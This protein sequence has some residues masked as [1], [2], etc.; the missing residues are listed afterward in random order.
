MSFSSP[1][2]RGVGLSPPVTGTGTALLVVVAVAL[3]MPA[4]ASAAGTEAHDSFALRAPAGLVLAR[5]HRDA[6]PSPSEAAAPAAAPA[7]PA[8]VGSGASDLGFDLLGPGSPAEQPPAVDEEKVKLRRKMLTYH[9]L[10]GIGLLVC[11]TAT[12][13]VGQLNYRD[14]FGGGPSSGR[15][16]RPHAWLAGTTAALFVGTGLLA[17]LAPNP[18]GKDHQGFDRVMLHKIGMFTAAAGIVAEIVLGIYTTRRE[19]H[20]NQESY[21]RAHLAI[22]Y[23]TLAA[24]YIGVGSIVF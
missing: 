22:G 14:R 8:A 13:A 24:T 6:A 1:T 5:S 2:K 17:I 23:T 3:A 12:V 7:S 16:E 4:Q 19:G 9:P 15:Y 11:E 20:L 21:A 10:L 18:M